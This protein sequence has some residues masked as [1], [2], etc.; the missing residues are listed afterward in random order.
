MEPN[1][2]DRYEN[3]IS[4]ADEL[5]EKNRKRVKAS[6]IAIVLL[7][8]VLGFVRWMTD[9]DKIVFLL[10]WVLCMFVLAAY[11]VSVEY[12]DH[13]LQEKLNWITGKEKEHE[14]LLDGQE[15]ASSK[16]R[17]SVRN[18]PDPETAETDEEGGGE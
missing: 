5:H 12:L 14:S 18:M 6:G 7:P 4:Y 10:I 9:S 2:N 16:E 17:K 11:L 3:L 1:K 15:F 13:V 8:I